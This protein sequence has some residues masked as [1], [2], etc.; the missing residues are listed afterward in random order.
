MIGVL[1]ELRRRHPDLSPNIRRTLERR[2]QA[3]RALHGPEQEV[4]LRQLHEPGRQGP[5]DFTDPIGVD[6]VVDAHALARAE[7]DLDCSGGPA[8]PFALARAKRKAGSASRYFDA[9]LQIS[10]RPERASPQPTALSPPRSTGAAR[11][12]T[13]EGYLA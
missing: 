12:F 10:S 8:S 13:P 4:I 2:I 6:L 1:Q 11:C 9:L 7:F 3:W 5:S